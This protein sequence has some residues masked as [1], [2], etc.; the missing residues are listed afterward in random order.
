MIEIDPKSVPEIRDLTAKLNSGETITPEE[1]D[2]IVEYRTS[3]A[4]NNIENA[5]ILEREEAKTEAYIKE[6]HE[7]TQASLVELKLKALETFE[8]LEATYKVG[9][10]GEE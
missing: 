5:R 10:D 3:I 7:R 4:L 9:S 8:R 1:L 6:A 2:Q